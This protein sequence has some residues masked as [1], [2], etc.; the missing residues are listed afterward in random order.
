MYNTPLGTRRHV[1]Y[2][3][4]S[5]DMDFKMRKISSLFGID[6]SASGESLPSLSDLRTTLE[7]LRHSSDIMRAEMDVQEVG[8]KLCESKPGT[9]A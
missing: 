5:E 4:A 8:G 9:T 6:H 2:S 1:Y 7:E 3:R